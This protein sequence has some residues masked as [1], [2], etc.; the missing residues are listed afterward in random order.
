MPKVSKHTFIG[1]GIVIE[2]SRELSEPTAVGEEPKE[3]DIWTMQI[4]DPAGEVYEISF[5][6]NV[7][8]SLISM[9]TGGVQLATVSDLPKR[10][11]FKS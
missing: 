9:L 1:C 10:D 11:A 3:I 2:K 7:K 8:D 5:M 4:Q 6:E